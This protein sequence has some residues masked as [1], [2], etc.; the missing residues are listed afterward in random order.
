[1]GWGR[2]CPAVGSAGVFVRE[3][4]LIYGCSLKSGL[5]EVIVIEFFQNIVLNGSDS[6]VI[7]EHES[8]E[9][10]TINQHGT[11][12]NHFNIFDSLFRES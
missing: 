2:R 3:G 10:F 1:L 11:F 6:Q 12:T 5:F 9:F 8:C 4:G 7:F